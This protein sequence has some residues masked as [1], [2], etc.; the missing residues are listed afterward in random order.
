LENLSERAAFNREKHQE[1]PM[2]VPYARSVRWKRRGTK[3][4]QAMTA[5]AA[6][7]RSQQRR[8]GRHDLSRLN[9]PVLAG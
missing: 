5:V 1:A 2:L 7:L 6:Q 3:K 9:I 8:H 4:H